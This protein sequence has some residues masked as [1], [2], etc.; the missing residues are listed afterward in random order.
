MKLGLFFTN[1]VSLKTWEKTGN[2][3]REIKPY[4]K[5]LD[6]FEKI[7]FLTY[8]KNEPAI[9][10]IKILPASIFNK[11]LKYIDVFK[12]N[13]INGSF[14]AVFAKIIYGKKLV[15]RQGYQW[16]I[17]AKNKKVPFFKRI[18]ISF[19]ERITYAISDAIMVSSKADREYIIKKYKLNPEKVHYIPNYIDT[20][21]FKHMDVEKENRICTVAKLEKQKNLASLIDAVKDLKI[22][23][24]IFGSGSL[25]ESLKKNLPSNVKIIRFIENDK[26]PVE[27]NKSKLF[28]LPSYYEGC[29]KALLEAMSCQVPVIGT[30][31]E[32]IK[33]I[34]NH[35]ENGYLCE[36]S[37]ASIKNAIEEV[38]SDVKMQEKIAAGARKTIADN[39]SLDIIFEKETKIYD[40]I[41]QSK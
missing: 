34:I 7:Y 41:F 27:I 17:F 22:G 37:S 2:L 19:I 36:T 15:A 20:D 40:K 12:T 31:V 11:E 35:K 6:Y 25:E 3:S 33:E 39:F 5:L 38:L 24:T 21:L 18:I 1:N 13:Q 32:G 4:I 23:L 28:I 30:N 9:A 16:S 10:G 8:G 26:L 14:V 29:P